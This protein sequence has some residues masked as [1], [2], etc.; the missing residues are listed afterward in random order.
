MSFASLLRNSRRHA[1]TS[2][3]N[4]LASQASGFNKPE[5]AN[6]RAYVLVGTNPVASAWPVLP[7]HLMGGDHDVR[8]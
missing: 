4:Y 5:V 7:G 6:A 3:T 2:V 1:P 8:L